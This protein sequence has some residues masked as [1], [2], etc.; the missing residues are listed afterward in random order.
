[1]A[2][3]GL[4]SHRA[5]SSAP[6]QAQ[7]SASP[8]ASPS[9]SASAS[10]PAAGF[11]VQASQ[12]RSRD[13]RLRHTKGSRGIPQVR[14]CYT[15]FPTSGLPPISHFALFTIHPFHLSLHSLSLF[16][17]H[18]SHFHSS[19]TRL[20]LP[21]F[22]QRKPGSVWAVQKYI[23]SPLLLDGRKFD[24]RLLALIAPNPAAL[25]G[26]RPSPSEVKPSARTSA[27]PS[28]YAPAGEMDKSSPP[29]RPSPYLA[30][31]YKDSYVRTASGAYDPSNLDDR[32]IHLV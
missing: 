10:A 13:S 29:A 20:L 11:H 27:R 22:R 14:T 3:C 16:L 9:A 12:P 6:A 17:P 23:E 30:Y 26:A 32:S 15:P 4:S 8:S 2:Q 18:T 19:A 25:E 1:M 31:V 7:V 28:P 21:L 5:L 24:I